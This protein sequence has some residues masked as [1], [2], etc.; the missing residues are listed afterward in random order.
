[1]PRKGP[2]LGRAVDSRGELTC[3]TKEDALLEAERLVAEGRLKTLAQTIS[4]REKWRSK[5]LA[6]DAAIKAERE[7]RHE[8]LQIAREAVASLLA[9]IDLTNAERAG[10][11]AAQKILART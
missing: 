4:D 10:L 5:L 11:A 6:A 8:E 2:A 1:M 9:R 7:A 3:R